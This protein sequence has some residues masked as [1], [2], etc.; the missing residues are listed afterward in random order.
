LRS[1]LPSAWNPVGAAPATVVDAVA[2]TPVL[3]VCALI[4]AAFAAA[5]PA[6]Q[7]AAPVATEA[8]T[9]VPLMVIVLDTLHAVPVAPFALPTVV[10]VPPHEPSSEVVAPA[11]PNEITW[12]AL[13]PTWNCWLWKLPSRMFNPLNCVVDATRPISLNSCCTS[14]FSAVRSDDE[15]VEFADCSA[16]S[17]IRCRLLLISPIAPSAVCA[18]EM[19]SLALRAAWF[20]PLICEVNREAIASPAASSFALLMRMP[21]DSRASEVCSADCDLLRLFCAFSDATLVLMTC[22]I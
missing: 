18:S 11:T 16:S 5:L 6:V 10:P 8:P 1:P 2:D 4:V 7:P 14:E 19:P 21:D 9:L 22:A 12:L 13:A 20:R 3:E 17:R 15:L